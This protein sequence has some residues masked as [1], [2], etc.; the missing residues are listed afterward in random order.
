MKYPRPAGE[1]PPTLII[2]LVILDR[3]GV[4]GYLGPSETLLKLDPVGV[5]LL[6]SPRGPSNLLALCPMTLLIYSPHDDSPPPHLSAS[7]PKNQSPALGMLTLSGPQLDPSHFPQC[8]RVSNC[9]RQLSPEQL[10][11]SLLSPCGPSAA[12]PS[13][14]PPL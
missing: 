7:G 9:P 6:V 11:Q 10:V 4:G 5:S 14:F 3:N 12:C 8:A 2:P 1:P 13:T